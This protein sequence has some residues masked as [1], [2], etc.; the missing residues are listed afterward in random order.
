MK[1]RS[2]SLNYLA[3]WTGS[4]FGTVFLFLILVMIGCQPGEPID[5]NQKPQFSTTIPPLQAIVAEVVGDRGEVECLLPPGRSPHSFSPTPREASR[6]QKSLAVFGVSESLEPWTTGLPGGKYIALV[7]CLP[8][9]FHREMAGGEHGEHG[10]EDHHPESPLDPHFWLDPMA[11][12][13]MLPGLV[14]TLKQVDPEGSDLYEINAKKFAGELDALNEKAMGILS[15]FKGEA[16]LLFHPSV[17]YL[18]DRYGLEYIGSIQSSPGKEPSPGDLKELGELVKK[19][20]V[21]ALFTEPQLSRYAGEVM[22]ENLGLP[23]FVL[24]PLGG[25]EG[26]ITYEELIM[27]N[28]NTLAGAFQ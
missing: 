11:V 6:A 8:E 27:Y 15:E 17:V 3:H 21:K 25:V 23:L 5:G 13:G 22:A 1:M 24:D 26:R 12:K 19:H 9:E 10:G 18:L 28:V 20:D 7:D 14:E 4:F 2:S 16:V